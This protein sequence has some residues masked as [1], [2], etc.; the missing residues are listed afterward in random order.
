MRRIEYALVTAPEAHPIVKGLRVL[1]MP[2]L[3][4]PA[5][6]RVGAVG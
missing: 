4:Y 3:L 1:G 2:V 6:A 5:E